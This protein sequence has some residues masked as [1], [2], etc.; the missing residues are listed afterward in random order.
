MRSAELPCMRRNIMQ[1]LL[2]A[3]GKIQCLF[4]AAGS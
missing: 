1:G 3:N 4:G 2:N